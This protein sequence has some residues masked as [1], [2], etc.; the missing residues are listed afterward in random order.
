[1]PTFEIALK[2]GRAF[3][4]DS[5][6]EPSEDQVLEAIN[7]Y[8]A[9]GYQ[10]APQAE[11]ALAT[12]G[13][14][15][16]SGILPAAGTVGGAIGGAALGSAAGPAGTIA[17]DI[18]GGYA[19]GQLGQGLM[20]AVMG[21]LEFRRNLAKLEANRAVNPHSAEIGGFFPMIASTLGGASGLTKVGREAAL[22]GKAAPMAERLAENAVSGARMDASLSGQRANLGEDTNLLAD[23]ARGALANGVVGFLPHAESVLQALGKGVGDAAAM[24]IAGEM[25]DAVK[26]G[27]APSTENIYEKTGESIPAFLLMNG[28]MAAVTRKPLM[29]GAKAAEV[30]APEAPAAFEPAALNDEMQKTFDSLKV[31]ED[32]KVAQHAANVG[33]QVQTAASVTEQ[34]LANPDLPE[35]AKEALVMGQQKM[36]DAAR[37]KVQQFA[38]DSQEAA[39]KRFEEMF[40]EQKAVVEPEVRQQTQIRKPEP[41]SL[42][43]LQGREVTFQG[44]HGTLAKDGD[45]WVMNSPDGT[46]YE[47]GFGDN[48]P[49]SLI[50]I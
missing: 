4:I 50:H 49:L 21:E 46:Q 43:E 35:A 9:S 12:A 22:A 39:R 6:Q 44:E 48:I 11:G 18:A 30:A 25:F 40:P 8:T 3:Q 2:D 7:S 5:E 28:V 16:A 34:T 29:R 36:S 19:G 20:R 42:N 24:T 45:V 33:A 26:E 10:D 13:R 47:V 37:G 14:E 27:R 38:L 23:T 17:G 32:A 31:E 15:L 1:M 41:E